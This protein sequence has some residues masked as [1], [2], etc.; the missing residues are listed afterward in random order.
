M[1]D[2]ILIART[3]RLGDVLLT[4]PVASALR[5][6]FPG[7]HITWLV[8]DYTAPLL[9]HNPDVDDILIDHGTTRE[10]TKQL[11]QGRFDAAIIAFPRWRVVWAAWR[12]RIPRRVGP[13]SKLYSALL[14]D[15]VWQHRSE[16]A[17]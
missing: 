11:Q 3:D 10:L 6:R 14:T 7:V 1:P 4:T 15:R 12:A 8:R 17:K 2:R 13:A 16:G 5:A 9:K